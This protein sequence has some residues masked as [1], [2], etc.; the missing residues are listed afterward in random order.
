[1][2]LKDFQLCSMTV[3][4]TKFC[5]QSWSYILR[6]FHVLPNFPFTTYKKSWLLVVKYYARFASRVAEP[7]K[8]YDFKKLGKIFSQSVLFHMKSAVPP[9]YFVCDCL[10][11]QFFA[12]SL[13]QAPSNL[14]CSTILVTLRTLKHF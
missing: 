13:T 11:K 12:C 2:V 3:F 5:I 4:K 10:W 8:T 1:M 7:F 14:I 6:I 9:R